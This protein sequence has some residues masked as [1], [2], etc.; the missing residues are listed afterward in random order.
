MF[1]SGLNG[2]L[3]SLKSFATLY[4]ASHP[5]LRVDRFVCD[6][7]LLRLCY[8]PRLYQTQAVFLS[9]LFDMFLCP[10]YRFVRRLW[11]DY[12][13]D[14]ATRKFVRS[15][16]GAGAQRTFVEFILDPLYK[17]YVVCLLLFSV[18]VRLRSLL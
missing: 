3:F 17:L 10:A 1:A 7:D 11:G 13:F 2:W 4:A 9:A 18:S 15:S 6:F 5:G 14:P 16:P 12:Y 8:R